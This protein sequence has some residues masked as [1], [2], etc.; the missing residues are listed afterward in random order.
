MRSS[1]MVNNP[2]RKKIPTVTEPVADWRDDARLLAYAEQRARLEEQRDQA[3]SALAEA[4][5][6]EAAASEAYERAETAA[7]LGK[8]TEGASTDQPTLDDLSVTLDTA[9]RTTRDAT[10][11]LA[12]VTRAIAQLDFDSIPVRDDARA[13]CARALRLAYRAA[14]L[15]LRDAMEKASQAN[16]TLQHLHAQAQDAFSEQFLTSQPDPNDATARTYTTPDIPYA[17]GLPLLAWP[18][19]LPARH[20]EEQL[21]YAAGW[22]TTDRLLKKGETYGREATPYEKEHGI[23]IKPNKVE[24]DVYAPGW[25]DAGTTT[26]QRT[27]PTRLSEWQAEVDEWLRAVKEQER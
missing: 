15:R 8:V 16:A 18:D 3:R 13:E 19:L 7:L 1:Q 11:H 4:R 14:A 23:E 21:A 20:Y 2:L 12:T 9:R 6:A 10:R 24:R 22:H 5:R 17:A 27:T 25:H 26:L